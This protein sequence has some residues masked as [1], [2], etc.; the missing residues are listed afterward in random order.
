MVCFHFY[1]PYLLCSYRHPPVMY[2]P[3]KESTYSPNLRIKASVFLEASPTI[4]ALPP[5]AKPV[6]AAL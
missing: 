5:R 6:T 2:L 4:T 1:T 3:P